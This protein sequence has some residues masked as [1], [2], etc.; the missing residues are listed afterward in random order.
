MA[1]FKPFNQVQDEEKRIAKYNSSSPERAIIEGTAEIDPISIY[2]QDNMNRTL[3]NITPNKSGEYIYGEYQPGE[4]LEERHEPKTFKDLKN[5]GFFKNNVKIIHSL[6]DG[7]CF[8]HSI[9]ILSP[10]VNRNPDIGI[11][12][13]LDKKSCDP[14]YIENIKEEIRNL[15]IQQRYTDADL[16]RFINKSG[17]YFDDMAISLYLKLYFGISGINIK[18]LIIINS[19]EGEAQNIS[20]IKSNKGSDSNELKNEIIRPDQANPDKTYDYINYGILIL[21]REVGKQPHYN[22]IPYKI[23]D[24]FID[25]I[26]NKINEIGFT[27]PRGLSEN[28]VASQLDIPINEL[29]S[30]STSS[31]SSPSPP[32]SIPPTS[33]PKPVQETVPKPLQ[34]QEQEPPPSPSSP[35]SSPRKLEPKSEPVNQ[36]L[37]ITKIIDDLKS[38]DTRF[39]NINKNYQNTSGNEP[40]PIDDLQLIG[41][42]DFNNQINENINGLKL[43]INNLL[44]QIQPTNQ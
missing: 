27:N 38:I 30:V 5:I 32:P 4:P 11:D 17:E 26:N 2:I 8:L 24:K 37:S 13:E 3:T 41:D 33:K 25:I 44:A 40:Q 20:I 9:K 6:A 23:N 14:Q 21:H 22:A 43:D 16:E 7:N 31:T 36:E 34:E 12:P 28:L 10:N 1:G 42:P 18:F 29:Q 15:S 19:S 39:D 35:S